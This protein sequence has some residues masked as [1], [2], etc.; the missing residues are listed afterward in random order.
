M[1]ETQKQMARKQN[2]LSTHPIF[3]FIGLS[4]ISAE[5]HVCVQTENHKTRHLDMGEALTPTQ[6]L[7]NP[8]Q[9]QWELFYLVA[10][11]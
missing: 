1:D 6:K 4:H 5:D 11:V 2:L 9:T 10:I 7:K 8:F 3:L